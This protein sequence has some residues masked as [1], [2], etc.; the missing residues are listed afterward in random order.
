MAIPKVVGTETEYGISAV[1]SPDFNPVISSSLLIST[2]TTTP[3]GRRW[4]SNI[5]R[6]SLDPD[7]TLVVGDTEICGNGECPSII[8]ALRYKRQP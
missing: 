7:G 5:L 4:L 1:G 3:D 6:W 8:T 2:D